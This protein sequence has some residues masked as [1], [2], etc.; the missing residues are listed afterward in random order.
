MG[1]NPLIFLYPHDQGHRRIHCKLLTFPQ[2][3]LYGLVCRDHLPFAVFYD[4]DAF[5]AN[6]A[7]VRAAFPSTKEVQFLHATAV[8]TILVQ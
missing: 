1:V 2:K 7:D 4:V 5:R 6:L 3:T 8:S